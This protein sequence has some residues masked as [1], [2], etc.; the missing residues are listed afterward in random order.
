MFFLLFDLRAAQFPVCIQQA[1]HRPGLARC[2]AR[3]VRRIAVEDFAHHT[4]PGLLQMILHCIQ[5]KVPAVEL[6]RVRIKHQVEGY[7]IKMTLSL[8]Y[9]VDAAHNCQDL[10]DYTIRKIEAF[11]GIS[12]SQLSLHIESLRPQDERVTAASG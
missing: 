2:A 10:H 5:E 7:A 12:I 6:Q 1:C 4:Q 8:P 11:A 9:G 3:G